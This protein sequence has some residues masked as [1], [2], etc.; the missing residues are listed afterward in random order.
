[1]SDDYEN[2]NELSLQ[3]N[4]SKVLTPKEVLS[5]SNVVLASSISKKIETSDIISNQRTAKLATL[6]RK[7]YNGSILYAQETQK[8]TSQ[9]VQSNNPLSNKIFFKMCHILG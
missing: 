2:L 5:N 7:K 8:Q 9:F 3:I 1:M 6:I 4:Q